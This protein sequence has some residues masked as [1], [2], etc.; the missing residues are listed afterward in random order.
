MTVAID[1]EEARGR[2]N[3]LADRLAD[4]GHGR[5][6]VE[7]VRAV[8]RHLFVPEFHTQDPTGRW[9]TVQ[10]ADPAYLDAVYSNLALTT[11]LTDGTPDGLRQLTGEQSPSGRDRKH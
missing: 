10:A 11:Q 9:R 6:W 7:A 8:P 5:R 2:R 4:A 3:A 1:T